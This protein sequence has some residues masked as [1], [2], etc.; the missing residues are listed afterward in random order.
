M[1]LLFCPK[2]QDLFR[3]DFELKTC[4]CGEVKGMYTGKTL[5]ETNGKGLCLAIDNNDILRVLRSGP[6][7]TKKPIECWFRPHSGELNPNSKV[8]P[9]L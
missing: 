9:E 1:K 2:C 6:V 3:L 8:N 7:E 5:S 4:K